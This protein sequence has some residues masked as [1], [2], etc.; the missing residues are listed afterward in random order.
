MRRKRSFASGLLL[1]VVLLAVLAAV[2]LAGLYFTLRSR[3]EAFARGAVFQL[4]YTVESAAAS[5]S[6]AYRTF[7]TFGALSGRLEGEAGAGQLA[8]SFHAPGQSAPF[9]D[10][11]SSE[12]EFYLN[13]G[14]LY[15]TYTAALAEQYPLLGALI[16]DWGLGDYLSGAQL[17]LLL[18]QEP[19]AQSVFPA[20]KLSPIRYPDGKDGY[21]YLA[22]E[23][24][25]AAAPGL[26]VGV[27][28]STLFSDEVELHILAGDPAN[29][30]RFVLTGTARAETVTLSP[31]ESRMADGDVEALRSVFDAVR[32][33][34]EFMNG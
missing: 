17:A 25:D 16:P 1:A 4:D 18:G 33:L 21:L 5:P 15:R 28:L 30:L 10:L 2:G 27:R 29:S 8:L 23:G 24:A 13:V 7:E 19:S 3:A 31:P 12:G 11:Y 20:A 9:L 22:P 26:L 32:E 14:R 6:A 34:A